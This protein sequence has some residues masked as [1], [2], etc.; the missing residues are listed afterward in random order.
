MHTS[1]HLRPWYREPWPWMLISLPLATVVAGMLTLVLAITSNDGLVADDYYRQGLGINR[2]M[3]R[4]RAAQALGLAADLR[5]ESEAAQVTVDL[6]P[7]TTRPP[8]LRLS[9]AHPTQ[10]ALDR[11]LVLQPVSADR[12]A[13]PLSSPPATRWR[14]TLEDA[15]RTWQLAGTWSPAAGGRIAP[16]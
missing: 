3:S 4:L 6:P 16:E 9:L 10:P 5:W 8:L 1:N 15:Q 14:V 12:Y 2:E 7:H 13:G 11:S